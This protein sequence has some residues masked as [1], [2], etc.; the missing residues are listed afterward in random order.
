MLRAGARVFILSGL[1]A[2]L[3]ASPARAE[4][5]YESYAKGEEALK[6]QDWQAAASHFTQ[7]IRQKP[8]PGVGVKTYG[9]NFINYHPYLKLGIAYF[10]MGRVEQALKAFESEE[11]LGAISASKADL[12]NLKRF[13]QLARQQ[14]ERAQAASEAEQIAAIVESSLA[15]AARLERQ[16]SLAEALKALGSGLSV[17]EKDADLQATLGRLQEKLAKD[18]ESRAREREVAVA[19]R[20]ARELLETESFGEAAAA[21][22]EALSL[23]PG[24]AEAKS[25]LAATA[26]RYSSKLAVEEKVQERQ[27]LIQ[28]TLAD[29]LKHENKGDLTEALSRLQIVLVLDPGNAEASKLQARLLSSKRSADDA[30]SRRIEIAR[31]LEEGTRSLEGG[32]YEASVAS[33]NRLITL[34]PGNLVARSRLVDSFGRMSQELLA[35]GVEPPKPK[36]PPVIALFHTANF[37]MPEYGPA[38]FEELVASPRFTLSGLVVDDQD[39]VRIG[40]DDQSGEETGGIATSVEGLE[41]AGK[42]GNL[43]QYRFARSFELAR[44]RSVLRVVAKDPD[45]LIAVAVHRVQYVPP[46]WRRPWPYLLAGLMV[47]G[48]LS[49]GGIM[50]VRRRNRLLK[51]RFNPFVAGAPVLDD[52]MFVGREPLLSRILQTIHNNSILLYGERRIGKT[53]LQHH[54]KRRLER[55]QDPEYEFFPVYIDLQGTPEG[56]FFATVARDMFHDLEHLL[57]G[58]LSARAPS[59]SSDYSYES[60]IRDTRSVLKALKARSKKK[61]KLVLLIDEVDELND[62]NPRINQ[63]LRSLFMKS[64]AEDLVAVVSGV[65]IKKHWESEGSPW[66][67]F[68]EELEVKPFAREDAANLIQNPIR[69]VFKME[70]GVVDRIIENTNCRPYL[71]QKVCVALVNRLH[72]DGRRRITVADV[73]AI[74]RPGEI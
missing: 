40:F 69:G 51:R 18:E 19:V 26:L 36:L 16:G 27:Q 7:A 67:N 25:L 31:L 33:F 20:R 28:E 8:E 45:G 61:I 68:F 52:D 24:H 50:K 60:L 3:F 59:E 4:L 39:E 6:G 71:I 15:E 5:W 54:L 62:Y 47:S 43:Y 73:D 23:D 1:L 29:V 13:Q 57:D 14:L 35:R 34:D 21:L 10:N 9:M 46:P 66:Y 49:A 65:G 17:N 38:I 2:V 48:A 56:R 22:Q 58:D 12:Q 53:S 37:K 41:P 63:K 11:S 72:D 44:G 30:A 42:M 74:G 32:D 64:F 70:P 55:I